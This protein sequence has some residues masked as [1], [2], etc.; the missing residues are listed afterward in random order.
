MN[1]I[2]VKDKLPSNGECIVYDS[3]LGVTG[4]CYDNEYY[5]GWDKPKSKKW[6]KEHGNCSD[7]WI[8]ENVTHWMPLP[9]KPE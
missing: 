9:E 6:V 3:E 1:W 7:D 2:S 8:L 4:C 5:E